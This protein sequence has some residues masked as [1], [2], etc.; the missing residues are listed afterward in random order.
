MLGRRA[1]ALGLL[2]AAIVLL[3]GVAVTLGSA[4]LT[5]SEVYIAILSRFFPGS[6]SVDPLALTIVWDLRLHRVI[7]A[8]LAGFG[9]A[10]AG[11]TMQGVLRNPLAS[12]FTLGIA[13]AAT[14]GAAIAI[15]VIPQTA[16][17]E[18]GIVISA[19]FASLIAAAAI[20][21]LSRYR[22][23]SAESMVLAGIILMYLFGAVTS[24]L[25]Y[26]GS[27][28]QLQAV[29]FWMFG[30]L[31]RTSWLKCGIVFLVLGVSVPYVIVRAWDLNALAMGDQVAQ[32]L[33]V[34]VERT[35]TIHM[36]IASLI[37]ASIICFTGTIGFIGLVS[38][39]IT[40]LA[41]GG[42]NRYLLIASGLIGALIL[43][44]ADS[45]ART[46]LAPVIIPV[47]IMTSFIGIPFF[48]Y[49]FLRRKEEYW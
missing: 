6:V 8:V 13:S 18:A 42:D 49:L 16:V 36:F 10:I 21:G 12:P 7:F 37:T 46:I 39:H 4:G 30:S 1:V 25:Q 28:E 27:T 48:L 2:A 31:Q 40:R 29:V 3:A 43:L 22:G 26:T 17:G 41:L 19:F 11:A 32:S 34:R 15:M 33:G 23:M 5:V 38:P 45:L 47:G 24:F 44:L 14:F 9:L 35:R 20:Y